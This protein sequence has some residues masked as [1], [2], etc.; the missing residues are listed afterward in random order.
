MFSSPT[1]A[2]ARAGG[3]FLWANFPASGADS[4]ILR[5]MIVVGNVSISAWFPLQASACTH[6][7][8]RKEQPGRVSLVGMATFRQPLRP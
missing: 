4:E 1:T 5:R 2:R 7:E 3:V 6:G 8:R